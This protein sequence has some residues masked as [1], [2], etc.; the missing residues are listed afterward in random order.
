MKLNMTDKQKKKFVKN[1]WRFTTPILVIFFTQL[2]TGVNWK[3]SVLVAL[4]AF[5]AAIADYLSKTK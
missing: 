1:L 5:Y 4:Y 2:A 3:A